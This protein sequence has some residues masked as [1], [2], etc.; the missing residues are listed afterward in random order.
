M[1]GSLLWLIRSA[2]IQAATDGTEQGRKVMHEPSTNGATSTGRRRSP[3]HPPP[4]RGQHPTSFDDDN[5]LVS[6]RTVPR[7]GIADLGSLFS[8]GSLNLTRHIRI[9]IR[10]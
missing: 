9:S 4:P 1:I 8:L 2:A 6:V 3:W 10:N 5:I 7:F